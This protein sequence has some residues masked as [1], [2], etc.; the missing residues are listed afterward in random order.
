MMV[1]DWCGW[2]H[3]SKGRGQLQWSKKEGPP[4]ILNILARKAL[5]QVGRFTWRV[6]SHLSRRR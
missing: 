6:S 1:G 5:G 3:A 2:S 4:N